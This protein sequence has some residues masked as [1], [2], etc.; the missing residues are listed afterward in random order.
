MKKEDWINNILES[1]SEIKQVDANP[2]MFNKICN[3][4]DEEE[5][6]SL[7]FARFK[8]GWAILVTLTIAINVS[9]LLFYNS[10]A[11]KLHKKSG[12]ESLTDEINLST[13][14]NY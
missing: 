7:P 3:Q 5:D 1:A 9:T 8:V 12:I 13:T 11:Q 4:L 6:H 14:Y 10:K 2:F